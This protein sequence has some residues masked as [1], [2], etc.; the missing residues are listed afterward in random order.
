MIMKDNEVAKKWK[1]IKI[2]KLCLKK[3]RETERRRKRMKKN[4]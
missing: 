4:I 3:R 1:E 2:S